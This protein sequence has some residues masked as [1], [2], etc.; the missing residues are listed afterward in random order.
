MN[1]E[2]AK[3]FFEN[4]S[5]SLNN[6]P[7]QHDKFLEV[8]FKIAKLPSYSG[9][10]R[11][12]LFLGKWRKTLS[13]SFFSNAALTSIKYSNYCED[14]YKICDAV[15][16][17]F[18]IRLESKSLSDED[19]E[20]FGKFMNKFRDYVEELDKFGEDYAKEVLGKIGKI[21]ETDITTAYDLVEKRKILKN[22]KSEFYKKIVNESYKKN[23]NQEVINNY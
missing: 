12:S 15:A 14:Y 1:S 3:S 10:D 18:K 23:K 16:D 22:E 17:K 9:F 19:H 2:A 5:Y 6:L 8:G 20:A 4:Y 11:V 13:H 21:A 7:E